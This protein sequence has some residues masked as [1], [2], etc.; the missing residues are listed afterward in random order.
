MKRKVSNQLTGFTMAVLGLHSLICSHAV[1]AQAVNVTADQTVADKFIRHTVTGITTPLPVSP[2]VTGLIG[3][4]Y[5]SVADIDNNGIL[6]ILATSGVGPDSNPS[7]AD[8]QVV[9]YTWNGIDKDSWT[10]TILPILFVSRM[11]P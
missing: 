3:V 6:D 8:G 4:S 5:I 10:K 7:S 2:D 9:L 11:K 1:F